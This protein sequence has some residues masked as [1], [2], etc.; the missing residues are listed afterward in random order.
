MERK[1]FIDVAKGIAMLLVVMQHT[2]GQLDPGMR[3]LCKV[4]V[5]LFFLCSG[6]LAYR[7]HIDVYRQILKICRRIFVP[8]IVACLFA[9]VYFNESFL[10]VFLSSGKRG[11]W[12]LEA[13]FFMMAIFMVIHRNEK[14]FVAGSVLIEAGLLICSKFAPETVDNVLGI[15]YLS[16]YFPCFIIGALMRKHNVESLPNKWVGLVLLSMSIGCLTYGFNSTNVSF[17]AHVVGYLSFS[18]LTFFVIKRYTDSLPDR[19]KAAFGYV[20]RYSLNVYIIHFYFVFYLP[21]EGGNF[22]IDFLLSASAA[23][24]VTALS[25]VVGKILT[26]CTPLNKVLSA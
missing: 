24:V 17:L 26:Y 16:R 22:L 9:C 8:F 7:P 21:I 5:P 4:D 3:F 20:G 2:G 6:F 10:D 18:V 25:I 13:L 23:V 19:L 1:T 15:S 12:F 11:Y 14:L